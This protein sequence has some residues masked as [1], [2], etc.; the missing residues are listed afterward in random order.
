[1]VHGG[2]WAIP[3]DLAKASRA[4]VKNAALQ[5]SKVRVLVQRSF[6]A[7]AVKL[8]LERRQQLIRNLTVFGVL[9]TRQVLE[10]GGSAVD[11][12][13]AAVRVMEDDPA[14]DAGKLSKECRQMQ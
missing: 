6:S 11:A 3:D 10:D 4:G 2:A 7:D 5:G 14:F 9:L 13:E 12:V 1:M 8:S